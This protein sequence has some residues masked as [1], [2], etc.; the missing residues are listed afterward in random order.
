MQSRVQPLI[1]ME[2][3]EMVRDGRV[4][5]VLKEAENNIMWN[6]SK[7]HHKL[8]LYIAISFKYLLQQSKT[9]KPEL[10]TVENLESCPDIF[11]PQCTRLLTHFI[12]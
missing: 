9:V 12:L 10:H 4:E 8:M 1:R 5:V 11:I 2:D 3:W 6:T 7:A